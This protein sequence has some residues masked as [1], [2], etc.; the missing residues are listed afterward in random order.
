MLS[1]Y[2]LAVLSNI[3]LNFQFDAFYHLPINSNSN[4]IRYHRSFWLFYHIS[5]LFDVFNV[6][7]KTII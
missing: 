7:I 4:T 2:I 6:A 5:D 3:F 1:K